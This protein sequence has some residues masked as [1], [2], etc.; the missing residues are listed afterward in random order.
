MISS[1]MANNAYNLFFLIFF[2]LLRS[3]AAAKYILNQG[4][5]LN[6]SDNLV[7][8]NGAFTLKLNNITFDGWYLTIWYIYDSEKPCW[9]A[10]RDRPIKN[11]SGVL[12][13]DEEGSLTITDGTGEDPIKLHLSQSKTSVSAILQDNGNFV[14]REVTSSGSAGHILWQSFDSPTSAFL[15]GMKLGINHKTGQNWSLTSWFSK[16]TPNPG[17]FTLEWVPSEHQ[18]IIKRRGV[19]FWSSGILENGKFKNVDVFGDVFAINFTEHSNK[20]EECLT[21][22][23]IDLRGSDPDFKNTA[24]VSLLSLEYDGTLN[25]YS[26]LGIFSPTYDGECDGRTNRVSGCE[27]W[28]GPGCRMDGDMFYK[29]EVNID[30]SVANNSSFNETLVSFSDC[31]DICWNDCK[32][33]GVTGSVITDVNV[34][35]IIGCRLWYGPLKETANGEEGTISYM[36]IPGPPASGTFPSSGFRSRRIEVM[37]SFY[38][39]LY[40]IIVSNRGMEMDHSCCCIYIYCII[41]GWF[42]LFEMEKTSTASWYLSIW[43]KNDWDKP[44]WLAN[45]YRPIENSSGVLLT[46]EEVSPSCIISS[47]M[48]NKSTSIYKIFWFISCCLWASHVAAV[49]V[50]NQG[51]VLNSSAS[52]VSKNDLFTLR[53]FNLSSNGDSNTNYSYLGIFYRNENPGKPFWIANRDRPIS[54]NSGALVINETGLM[55]TFNGGKAPLELFSGQTNN[56]VTAILQDDGNFVLKSGEQIRWQS[57]DFPADSF[58]P[59]MKLGFNYKTGQNRSLT[60]WLTD[61]IPA[62]GAFSLDWDPDERQLIFRRRG[63]TF[64]TSGV[65]LENNTFENIALDAGEAD[66]KFIE[67]SNEEGKYLTYEFLRNQY[68]PTNWIN[69]TWLM[70]SYDGGMRDQNSSR[71]V[72]LPDLCDGNSISSGCK[73]WER[74]KCRSGGENFQREWCYF[75]GSV[76]MS[77]YLNASVSISD[78]KDICWKN[79]TC[80]GTA[81]TS[82]TPNSTGCQFWYGPL[83]QEPLIGMTESLYYIIRPG[84]PIGSPIG[85]V[86]AVDM[87]FNCCSSHIN[88][89]TMGYFGVSETEKTTTTSCSREGLD[90]QFPSRHTV[91]S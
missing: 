79:C 70:L 49:D 89:N 81:A 55:I 11:S 59:G 76:D 44:C 31:K 52:L 42:G 58:L 5:T 22:Q 12:L 40:N 71:M 69:V 67:V 32:C 85:T 61:S 65:L 66:H 9:I 26:S 15:P 73:R 41:V 63:V 84:P 43:Y 4:D 24:N 64:W 68:T 86:Q 48:A 16:V 78:C 3:H 51:D 8:R 35:G 21:Y 87:D 7:S 33:V 62:P 18:L 57:F 38:Y 83:D 29:K 37:D 19:R 54:D 56:K 39:Y 36:I 60:S 74:P 75:P 53:F 25:H 1:S 30:F 20:D 82:L 14:L 47:A 28:K 13:I 80:V 27:R 45:R 50:L 72:L 6:S 17:A 23:L 34:L 2:C 90:I 77:V 91:I 10:N 46:D 88:R